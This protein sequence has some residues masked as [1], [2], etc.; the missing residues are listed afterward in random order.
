MR[1]RLF[2]PEYYGEE[3]EVNL[4]LCDRENYVYGGLLA[5]IR[6]KTVHVLALWVDENLRGKGFGGE[7][8]DKIEMIALEKKCLNILLE[9]TNRHCPE[10]YLHKGFEVV[11]MVDNC[12]KE[13]RYYYFRKSL[14]L[15]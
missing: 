9:T 2:N 6:W 10:F 8:V 15:N 3:L 4:Y 7:L 12:P 5:N 13:S 11:G 1:K 14:Y